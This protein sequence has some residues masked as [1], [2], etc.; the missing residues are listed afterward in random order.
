MFALVF[1][2]R[3]DKIDLFIA[4]CHTLITSCVE[5]YW[6]HVISTVIITTAYTQ[7]E[8]KKKNRTPCISCRSFCFGITVKLVWE[9]ATD[10]VL[11]R[12]FFFSF[13]SIINVYGSPIILKLFFVTTSSSLSSSSSSFGGIESVSKQLVEFQ[14]IFNRFWVPTTLS[15]YFRRKRTEPCCRHNDGAFV[16]LRNWN[17]CFFF[18]LLSEQWHW[19]QS[20]KLMLTMEVENGNEFIIFSFDRLAWSR[21]VFS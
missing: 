16:E 9:Y 21:H 4:L 19:T 13:H 2:S 7:Q 17:F 14:N 18:F 6:L 15:E 11:L 1:Y 5:V 20:N 12:N 3:Y 8:K 10:V